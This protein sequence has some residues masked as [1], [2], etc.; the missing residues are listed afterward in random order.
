MLQTHTSSLDDLLYVLFLI[1]EMLEQDRKYTKLFRDLRTVN[2][3]RKLRDLLEFEK[4]ASSLRYT[5][6]IL[7]VLLYPGLGYGKPIIDRN[8]MELARFA[9]GRLDVD[10][11]KKGK[12]AVDCMI[13][14]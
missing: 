7:A 12:Q 8:L 2:P 3:F 13:D 6:H 10:E 11:F 14:M 9:K 4:D 5:T 1:D